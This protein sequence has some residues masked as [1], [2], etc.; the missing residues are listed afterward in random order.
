VVVSILTSIL[1]IIFLNPLL[2][3]FGATEDIMDYARKY[4]IIII[5]F[6]IFNYISFGLNHTIR[7]LGFP[8]IAMLTMII[9]GVINFILKNE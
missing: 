6:S 8:K 9:G 1:G 4:A 2:R 5:G 3:V 7:S